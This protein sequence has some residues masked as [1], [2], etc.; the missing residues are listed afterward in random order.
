MG[1]GKVGEETLPFVT[2]LA[3]IEW[4]IISI[5]KISFNSYIVLK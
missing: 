4:I 3:E 2:Q 5:L 1:T